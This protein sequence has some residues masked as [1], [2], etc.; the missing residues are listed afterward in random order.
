MIST[1]YIESNTTIKS[2]PSTEAWCKSYLYY[3]N[4]YTKT[5][6]IAHHNKLKVVSYL[7]SNCKL[8]KNCYNK[9]RNR[10]R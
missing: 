2:C 3:N 9:R 7:L 4:L 1:K 8:C 5:T 10:S 6:S